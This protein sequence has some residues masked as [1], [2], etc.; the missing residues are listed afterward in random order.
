[1]V[2]LLSRV[3]DEGKNQIEGEVFLAGGRR[4]LDLDG[5]SSGNGDEDATRVEFDGGDAV[6]HGDD[7]EGNTVLKQI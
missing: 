7:V 5:F 6:F 2:L 4:A 3:T 1:M